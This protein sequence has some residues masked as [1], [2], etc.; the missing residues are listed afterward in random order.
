MAQIKWISKVNGDWNTAA[1]WQGGV[2]PGVNDDVIINVTGANPVIT[3]PDGLDVTVKSITSVEKLVVDGSLTVTTG[4]STLNGELVV[5]PNK[6]LQVKDTA[7]LVANGATTANG[8]SL[9]A[10]NGGKLNLPALTSYDGGYD[11]NPTYIQASGIGSEVNLPNVTSFVGRSGEYY[12]PSRT[13][14]N[15]LAQGKINL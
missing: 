13:E 7:N 11:Y 6:Y 12:W 4:N 3:I 15:A 10:E 9:Y 1:N 5:N 8:A 14:V 2:V